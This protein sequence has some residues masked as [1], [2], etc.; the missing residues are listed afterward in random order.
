[1]SRAGDPDDEMPDDMPDE[2]ADRAGER[3]LAATGA[4]RAAVLAALI[5]AHPEHEHALRSIAADLE[6]VDGAL[7]DSYPDIGADHVTEAL[8]HIGAY[9]VLR[10]L[11]EGAFGVVWLC[12]QERPVAR[13]VAVKVVRS[14]AGGPETLRRFAAERQLLAAL[15]HATITQVFDAGELADGR[16]FF[17]ME[18]VAGSPIGSYCD[19]HALAVR[20][21]LQLFC[22]VCRGVAHAHA[23]GI[24]HR[25][26]KPANVL[27][28]DG[29]GGGDAGPAPKIIDF[30]IAKALVSAAAAGG[31]ATEA[32]RIVGTPGYMSPEQAS[33]RVGEVDARTDVFAL[34]VILYELLTGELPWAKGASATTSEPLRPSV[35]VAASTATTATRRNAAELRGDLDWI[36]MTALA[37]ERDDRYPSVAAFAADIDSH[38]RGNTVSVGPPSFWYRSSKLVRRHRGIVVVAAAALL[39]VAAVVVFFQGRTSDAENVADR[40]IAQ[41]TSAVER[42]L[43]RASDERIRQAPE[44]D[45][46]RQLLAQDA[47]GFYEQWLRERPLERRL[48]VGRCRALVSLTAVHFQLGQMPA[49]ERTAA[50]AV[51]E[52]EELFAAQ[53]DDVAIRGLLA[54]SLR[55]HGRALMIAQREPEA[56][57]RFERAVAHLEHC[58]TAAPQDHML[59]LSSAW[60]ELCTARQATRQPEASL[61]ANRRSVAVLEQHLASGTAK[62]MAHT[63]VA[64]ARCT[65]ARQLAGFRRLDEAEKVA[66]AAEAGLASVTLDVHRVTALVHGTR[67]QLAARRRDWEA[68]IGHAV[69]GVEAGERWHRLEPARVAPGDVLIDDLT[70]LA[71]LYDKVANWPESDRVL[72]RAIAIADANVAEFPTDVVRLVRLEGVLHESAF[73]LY[74]RLRLPDLEL[75]QACMERALA[76]QQPVIE[77]G[78]RT[79]RG[80]AQLLTV[81][82]TIVEAR[83]HA[84]A[85]MW[86]EVASALEVDI[87]VTLPGHEWDFSG[88][89]GVTID[90]LRRGDLDGA[91]MALAQAERWLGDP[92]KL[93][94]QAADV[95]WLHSRLAL[96]RGDVAAAI[97]AAER[98]VTIRPT[99]MGRWRA[100]DCRFAIW[101]HLDTA[102]ERV[103]PPPTVHRDEAAELYRAVIDDLAKDVRDA[104]DDPFHVVPWGFSSLQLAQ[105]EMARG[106]ASAA[107]QLLEAGTAALERVAP[108]AH[109]D[110]WQ[111]EVLQ[112]ANDLLT[113]LRARG[114]R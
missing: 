15:N 20:A 110:L 112:A 114:V 106:Q 22:E 83:G 24:V 53:P 72:H 105:I 74:E 108:L 113:D 8:D 97:A 90:R 45:V 102:T 52:A 79:Q 42:L 63:D 80:R 13:M 28:V 87:D 2:L 61:E 31:A 51:A 26:L 88:W 19:S 60:R 64:I 94:S 69:R 92:P 67:A 5:A 96:R 103:E 77:R 39:L 93:A 71:G 89:Q 1:M 98:I 7:A 35:R 36:V 6:R 37:R 66:T 81:L 41:A 18:Y 65:L 62:A 23:R 10:R 104:A 29:D 50:E 12:A 75:A 76:T 33:G 56:L 73:R 9:R 49:A 46:V 86:A 84:T 14:G 78:G 21:R 95:Q 54:E 91:A 44:N 111:P 107:R 109:R 4:T 32:G 57:P 100:A 85:A 82:A 55:R 3:L 48:R 27:V 38:L 11:G 34:G 59:S 70:D 30:G 16:P 101:R 43:A 58:A 68:A 25:D 47:L 99:W 40:A 17:V